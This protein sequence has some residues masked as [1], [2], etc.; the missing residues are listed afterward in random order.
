VATINE[1]IPDR[2]AYTVA[3][4]TP[5]FADLEIDVSP[6]QQDTEGARCRVGL[7]LWQDP[8]NYFIVNG[9]LDNAY[10]AASASTFFYFRGFE[11]IFDAVWSN[12]GD[13]VVWGK[14]FRL[15]LVS[16]GRRY[17][18]LVEDEPVLYRAFSDVYP[19]FDRLAINRVGVVANWEWGHD[20][21]SGVRRFVAR[22]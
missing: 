6:P 12:L 15:R 13:L 19:S 21:G 20:T 9:Y 10:P 17:L 16:D 18:V 3:W 7:V 1:P 22:R 4:S 5:E 14:P 2:T 11:D 8:R